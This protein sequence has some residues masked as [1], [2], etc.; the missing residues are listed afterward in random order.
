MRGGNRVEMLRTSP[1]VSEGGGPVRQAGSDQGQ[2]TE[3]VSGWGAELPRRGFGGRV[4]RTDGRPYLGAVGNWAGWREK[5]CGWALPGKTMPGKTMPGRDE[6]SPSCCHPPLSCVRPGVC[7][8]SWI[9]GSFRCF[10]T[11]PFT[12][13]FTGHLTRPNDIQL[14]LEFSLSRLKAVAKQSL[15][16]ERGWKQLL[17]AS[18][19]VDVFMTSGGHKITTTVS[20]NGCSIPSGENSSFQDRHTHIYMY[21]HLT[22]IHTHTYICLLYWSSMFPTICWFRPFAYLLYGVKDDHIFQKKKL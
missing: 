19:N 17:L 10:K 21:M 20:E 9:V 6:A 11:F 3:E 18:G 12:C 15:H 7:G 2:D 8:N 4:P 13:F 1:T 14:T 16:E 5:S 22:Y